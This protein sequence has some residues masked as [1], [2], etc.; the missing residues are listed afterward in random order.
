MC[1][2]YAGA[3]PAIELEGL[4]HTFLSCIWPHLCGAGPSCPGR[5]CW[6]WIQALLL[7][8]LARHQ[9]HCMASRPP[10][11]TKQSPHLLHHMVAHLTINPAAIMNNS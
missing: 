4:F 1:Q 8:C 10:V 3:R 2:D 9:E 7:L 11:S 6:K 5:P